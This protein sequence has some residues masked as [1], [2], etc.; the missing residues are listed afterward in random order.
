[1]EN[2]YEVNSVSLEMMD[3]D[4][5]ESSAAESQSESSSL[6]NSLESGLMVEISRGG[7]ADSKKLDECGGWTNE[8]HNSYIGSLEKTFVRQLYSLLG[9]GGETQPLNRTRGVQYKLT[10]QKLSFGNKRAHMGTAVQGNLLCN[11]QIRSSG[12]KGFARTSMRDSSGHEYQAQTTAEASG[13][14][15]REEE[16]AEEKGCN[17]EA[18]RKRRRG[19]NFDDS[20]LNDQVVP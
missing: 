10:D 14:N 4:A 6:S 8:K 1:M 2:E 3:R 20:S 18:S 5:V 19:A 12:D 11:D 15:F 9:R 17:S 16:V 7:D 13:Q